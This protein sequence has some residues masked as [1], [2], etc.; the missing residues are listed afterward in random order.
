VLNYRNKVR[1][2]RG[3]I[4]QSTTQSNLFLSIRNLL[5]DEV[6]E[7]IE[8]DEPAVK[9]LAWRIRGKLNI[10]TASKRDAFQEIAGADAGSQVL[11]LASR[12]YVVISALVYSLPKG[13]RF[14]LE[15]ESLHFPYTVQGESFGG[16]LNIKREAK[17]FETA[18]RFIEES[19]E[20][21]LLLLDGPLAFSNWWS[22]V[23]REEDRGKL[24]NGVKGLLDLCRDK[25]VTI[26]GVVKRPSARYLIYQ[27]G[28]QKETKLPDSF[29]L[30]HILEP[31]ERSDIFSPRA[32]VRKAVKTSPFLD[33]LGHTIYSFYIRLSKEWFIPPIRID[34]PD[35]CL[36]RL[37]DIANYCYQSSVWKGIPLPI[38][39]ADEEV[40]ISKRFIGEVYRDII[41]KVGRLTGE[42]SYLAPY[43][44]EGVWMGA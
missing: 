21:R 11:P 17:L 28:L 16:V 26:A 29:L 40:K 39:R 42:I 8:D 3:V 25:G 18:R 41:R 36:G 20:T 44:G 6:T 37:D 9:E 15:P 30:L 34:L 33:A 10:Y 7:H 1:E 43:W 38:L 19:R 14:F 5:L 2:E 22:V 27:L 24:I 13:R 35:Y 4:N 31:G 23:G 12:R 32:A